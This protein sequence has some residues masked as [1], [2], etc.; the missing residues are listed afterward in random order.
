MPLISKKIYFYIQVSPT[1]VAAAAACV[2][3]YDMVSSFACRRGVTAFPPG[4]LSLVP[5]RGGLVACLCTA[6]VLFYRLA[7]EGCRPTRR[8]VAAHAAAGTYFLLP[9]KK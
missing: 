6:G 8:K 9:P 3:P 2:M 7:G 4:G 1:G 5:Q